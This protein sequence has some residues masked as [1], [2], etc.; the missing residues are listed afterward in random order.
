MT[1]KTKIGL[2]M[3]GTLL[4]LLVLI[5]ASIVANINIYNQ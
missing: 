2:K 1:N 4:I 5:I 3:L